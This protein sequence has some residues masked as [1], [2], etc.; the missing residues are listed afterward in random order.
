MV[1]V[2]LNKMEGKV[3]QSAEASKIYPIDVLGR[4]LPARDFPDPKRPDW[5]ISFPIT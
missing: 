3:R 4:F 2:L 1:C 5:L